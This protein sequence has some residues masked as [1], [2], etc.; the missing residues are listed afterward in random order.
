[1]LTSST[2]LQFNPASHLTAS[3]LTP[4]NETIL[5]RI[6]S[7]SL[8]SLVTD[9]LG[10]LIIIKPFYADFAGPGA[11]I[12]GE[13]DRRCTA[14]YTVGNVQL[15]TP[16]THAEREMT[17]LTRVAYAEALT[18]LLNIQVPIRRSSLMI[19]HLCQ[20]MPR[21]IA[22]TIPA[23][24][25]GKLISVPPATVKLAWQSHKRLSDDMPTLVSTQPRKE[26]VSVG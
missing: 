2:T 26:L 20:W 13:F 23:E 25:I 21:D 16:V 7:G 10:G 1:M 22:E 4:L 17:I 3:G 12:G 24:L 15:Q 8:I 14:I 19:E 5:R 18:T 6:Q 11:A 9:S